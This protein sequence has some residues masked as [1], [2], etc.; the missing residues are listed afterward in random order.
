MQS[1][2]SLR[3]SLRRLWA[4]EKF[5]PGLRFFIALSLC[6]LWVWYSE[7]I[8]WLIPLYLGVI[9]CA[10]AETDDSWQGRLVAVGV[11]LVCF[12]LVA[13]A[14]EALHPYTPWL[15]LFM[16]VATIVLIVLGSA[17]TRFASISYATLIFAIYTMIGL[18]HQSQDGVQFWQYAPVLLSGAFIYGTLSVLWYALFA[19]QPL[20]HSLA[21]LFRA[22]C[23]Y[24]KAKSALFEPLRNL[25]V[26]AHRL[27]I[28]QQN[29]HVVEAL[30]DT[31]NIILHRV[32]GS[33][34]SAKTRRYLKLYFLAQDIHERASS[35]HSPYQKLTEA[36][37]HSDV[38]FRCLRLIRQQGDACKALAK[39]IELRQ[40]FDYGTGHTQALED[41]QASIAYLHQQ[42]NPE[43]R[44]LLRSLR[45]LAHNL[46]TLDQ[47]LRE[48][49]NPD[50][51]AM[52]Q[53]TAI[54]DR[55]PKNIS[56]AW[57]RISQNISLESSVFRHALRMGV[58][59]AAGLAIMHWLAPEQGYWIL[60]TTVFVCRPHYGATRK[61]LVQRIMGT[62][63][64]L[65]L[66]WMLFQLAPILWIQ[67]LFAIA[68]GVAYFATRNSQFTV[69]TAFM[70]LMMLIC[71][72]QIGH[73]YDLFL[74]RLLDTIVGSVIA[75]LAV[76]LILPD[77]QGRKLHKALARTL[78]A[79]S[80]YLRHI[81][82]EYSQGKTDDM[83]YRIARRDAHNADAALT[84]SLSNML[85]E[86]GHFRRQSDLGFR[87]LLLSHT[88][89]GYISALGAHRETLADTPNYP[90]LNREAQL[91]ADSLTQLATQLDTLQSIGTQPEAEQQQCYRLRDM[92]EETDDTLRL[93][94]TQ[95]LLI[96]QQ[97]GPLRSLAEEVIRSYSKQG[98]A[99]A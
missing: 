70:T 48:A 66:S 51:L 35:S 42:Q 85:K 36:F 8:D 72:N 77:W 11:T 46:A 99:K 33:R 2:F 13:T 20:Q 57:E 19:Q 80:Q 97:L 4:L 39:A 93:L 12:S 47:L 32:S 87:F 76:F 58:A 89:L 67:A 49:A 61:R 34:T 28:A 5:G 82:L 50:A 56:E 29:A 69:S 98:A 38:L 14:V 26:E 73:G 94:Q 55:E 68:A 83:Q 78:K 52:N 24:L 21:R 54:F 41:L 92:P 9:G 60:M 15:S 79:N 18:E 31:K 84:G 43:W 27:E 74:P 10:L 22:Q 90:S 59:V 86:P 23:D 16:V 64:G 40:S 17:G 3:L 53:D 88:L 81:M 44:E 95:L 75:G 6:T 63:L 91:L 71:F 65:A 96:S 37:F 25:D 1:S 30:N 7:R 62:V 45:A